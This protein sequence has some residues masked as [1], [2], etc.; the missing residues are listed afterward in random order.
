M[1]S[2]LDYFAP[3]VCQSFFTGN[4]D[5]HKDSFI[6]GD[7]LS[8][9][10]PGALGPW[11]RGA[12]AG[13][14]ATSGSTAGPRSVCPLLDTQVCETPLWPLVVWCWIPQLPQ[15]HFSLWTDAQLLLRVGYDEGQLIRPSC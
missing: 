10:S 6:V 2:I 3:T 14:Q 1:Y 8:H 12:G 15:K 7:Y 4:L 13:I 9:C 11:P 5:S